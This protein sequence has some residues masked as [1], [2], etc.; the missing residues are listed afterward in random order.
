MRA[1]DRLAEAKGQF[2]K[3]A[4]RDTA[5]LLR[6]AARKRFREPA[7]LIRFHETVLF[8]RANPA[9]PAVARRADEILFR[10][11]ERVRG[12]DPAP[13][14]DPEVSGIAGTAISTNFSYPFAASLVSRHTSDLSIDWD[15]YEHIDRLGTVLAPLIPHA[16]EEFAVEPHVDWRAWLTKSRLSLRRVIEK[17]DPRIY[18]L[19]ELPLCWHLR[20]V[21]ATRSG[22]R[23]PRRAMFYHSGP[24][25]QRREVSIESAFAEPPLRARRLPPTRARTVLGRIVDAS[26]TRYRELYGFQY[27]DRAHVY[28]ADLGRGMDLYFFGA[29]PA[30]RLPVRDYH[31]GMY[32]KNGVPIGYVE[33][34]TLS[35]RAE[36]GFNLYYTFRDGETAWLY[37]RILKFLRK[38]L[39]V[40][41]F[42]IDPYQLGH[43][44][45]EAIS[46]GA[47]WFYRKLGFRPLTEEAARLTELEEARIAT[48]PGY[49]T[50]AAVLRR[51]AESPLFYGAVKPPTA[52]S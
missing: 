19:V 40:T 46:S 47:F 34:M 3:N 24:F 8:L 32:F 42:S 4:A 21:A 22:L 27:P 28:H 15:N 36:V 20:D 14:D 38:H 7:D 30:R 13:F 49:R 18:D 52:R 35:K 43:E 50:P 11:A 39:D 44:N 25:L 31:A 51:L 10:F 26:A 33:T 41:A 9:S 37:T 12:I 1:L 29:S 5:E 48:R 45:E 23:L 16:A 17:T 2:G 6:E